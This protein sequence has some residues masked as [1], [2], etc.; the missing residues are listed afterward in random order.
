[1]NLYILRHGIAASAEEATPDRD[2]PLTDKGAKRMRREARGMVRL[3]IAFDMILTSP[4]P[5][6]RQTAEIVAEAMGVTDHLS[7][8]EAL[9]PNS[10]VHDL[11]SSLNNYHNSE[12]LLLVGHEPLLS[13]FAA[14]IV[15]GKK[16]A[17]LSMALKKGGLCRIEVDAVPPLNPGTLQWLLAPK[18]LRLLGGRGAK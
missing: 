4:L 13:S 7:P 18:Q 15:T 3:G 2:R 12:H 8:L 1:M 9:Q 10:S 5:R 17:A 11:L 6:A 14:F 16:S